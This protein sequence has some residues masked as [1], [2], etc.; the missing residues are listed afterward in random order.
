MYKL[1]L[2]YKEKIFLQKELTTQECLSIDGNGVTWTLN[3]YKKH[4]NLDLSS[5]RISD[6][7]Q[8]PSGIEFSLTEEDYI[9][10]RNSQIDKILK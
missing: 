1:I 7:A 9:N 5:Y 4:F 3:A 2:K 10:L 8:I 6:Y